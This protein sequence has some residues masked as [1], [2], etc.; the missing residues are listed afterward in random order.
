[1]QRTFSEPDVWIRFHFENTCMY[2]R[3]DLYSIL[4]LALRHRS[5][6]SGSMYPMTE[7]IIKYERAAAPT[8]PLVHRSSLRCNVWHL[9]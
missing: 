4:L 3:A 5:S 2:N 1:M 9:S 8:M 7:L 6:A